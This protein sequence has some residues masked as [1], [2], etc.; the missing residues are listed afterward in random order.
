MGAGR[1]ARCIRA[2]V[3][4]DAVAPSLVPRLC[5]SP[6]RIVTAEPLEGYRGD[7]PLPAALL[8]SLTSQECGTRRPAAEVGLLRVVGVTE[9]R[10]VGA[11]PLPHMEPRLPKT[12]RV[13]IGPLVVAGVVVPTTLAA[14]FLVPREPAMTGR[15]AP[16]SFGGHILRVQRLF[17]ETVVETLA[18]DALLRPPRGRPLVRKALRGETIAGL[19]L[20]LDVAPLVPPL[21]GRGAPLS[22]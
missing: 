3:V 14:W 2:V 21:G 7:E 12:L 15:E 8:V 4:R 1:L 13:V 20:A 16:A 19:G 10:A 11:R 22:P 9:A 18:G 6:P 5:V 17:S